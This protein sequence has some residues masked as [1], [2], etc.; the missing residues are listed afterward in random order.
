[1]LTPVTISATAP[2]SRFPGFGIDNEALQTAASLGLL[3]ELDKTRDVTIFTIANSAFDSK[4][5]VP[6][7][8]S[9]LQSLKYYVITPGVYY[10]NGFTGQS[11]KTLSGDNVTLAGFGKGDLTVNGVKVVLSDT[12]TVNGVIHVLEG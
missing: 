1:M 8:K 7:L 4:I 3:K 9:V 12:F 10:G 5:T 11:V 2:G 6:S